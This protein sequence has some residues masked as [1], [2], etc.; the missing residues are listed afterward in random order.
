MGV[1]G[2]VGVEEVSLA[3]ASEVMLLVTVGLFGSV[4]GSPGSAGKG[5]SVL[6]R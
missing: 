6:L 3:F 4:A 5:L 2:R 1:R